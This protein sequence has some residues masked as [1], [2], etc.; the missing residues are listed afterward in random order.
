MSNPHYTRAW[1]VLE[2]SSNRSDGLEAEFLAIEAGFDSVEAQLAAS[3]AAEAAT[4]A[5]VTAA[6]QGQAS[7]AANLTRYL[8]TFAAAT[9]NLDMGGFRVRNVPTPLLAGDLPNK[10][11]VDDVRAYATGLSFASALPGQ[12]GQAGKFVKTDGGTASW[13]DLNDEVPIQRAR[14]A[15]AIALRNAGVI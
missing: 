14:R 2:G 4:Q 9:G 15:G 13:A 3:D 1:D 8:S 11:Y 7:L 5:E 6:R 12:A 10:Q